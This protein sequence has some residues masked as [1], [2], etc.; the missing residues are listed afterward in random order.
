[1]SVETHR[2]PVMSAAVSARSAVLPYLYGAG[3][4]LLLMLATQE[5][6]YF[7][8]PI[9]QS[10]QRRLLLAQGYSG[11]TLTGLLLAEAVLQMAF[12]LIAAAAHFVAFYGLRRLKRW[13][14][15]AATVIA[16]LWSL[17]LV[18]IPV[19]VWL[20]RREVRATYG[21]D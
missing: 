3:A 11:E 18:G 4:V 15:L 16:A 14:W 5:L 20:T 21:V 7:L 19:L 6:A 10:A 2:A 1:M 9:S 13:G 8:N 12:L 17:V